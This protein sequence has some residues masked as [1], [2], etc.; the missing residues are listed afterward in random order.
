MNKKIC[1]VILISFLFMG[2]SYKG[3]KYISRNGKVSFFSYAS[4]EN[5]KAT[6]NQALS[7]FEPNTKK[8]AVSILM[9]AFGFEKSLMQEHF[10]DSYIES[11]IYPKATFEGVV[12]NFDK[13]FSG[14]QTKIIKG[15]FTLRGITKPL[16]IKAD[17][18]KTYKNYIITGE[19]ELNIKDYKIKIPEILSKR[20]AQTVKVSFNFKYNTYEK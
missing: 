4:S 5:I 19:A 16:K 17:I 8:I 6:N 13:N 10:N 7:L 20:I 14:T 15:D 9:S 11:E 2:F 12:L 18:T 1:F 3:D